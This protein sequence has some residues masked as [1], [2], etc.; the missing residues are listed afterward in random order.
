MGIFR[1]YCSSLNFL[2][3]FNFY[4]SSIN[5]DFPILDQAQAYKVLWPLDKTILGND[6]KLKQTPGYG[7]AAQQEEQKW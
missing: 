6:P 7:A 2:D 1:N 5:N 3:I 4:K